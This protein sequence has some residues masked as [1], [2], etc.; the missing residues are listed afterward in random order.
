MLTQYRHHSRL[1]GEHVT[2]WRLYL[3]Q[4]EK[5]LPRLQL[6]VVQR[7]EQINLRLLN[8]VRVIPPL[9]LSPNNDK[10]E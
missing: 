3:E 2:R 9:P 8:G 6:Y 4:M 10:P 5:S 7:G 1:Y